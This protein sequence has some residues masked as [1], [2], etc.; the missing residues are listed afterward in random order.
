MALGYYSRFRFI[1]NLLPLLKRAPVLRRVVVVFAAGFEGKI[2]QDNFQGHG[3]SIFSYRNQVS[4]LITL[5]LEAVAQQASGVSFVHEFPGMVNTPG[6]NSVEGV[7]G[8]VSRVL[9]RLLGPF[10]C[11]P[12]VQSGERHL[13]LATS[14]MYTPAGNEDGE[15]D[16]AGV[17]FVSDG[18]RTTASGT[19]DLA[20]SGVYSVGS[21]GDTS[22]S[23]V[24]NVL[25]KFRNTGM[26]E[27]I[28][29]H[30]EG[31]FRRI[32]GEPTVAV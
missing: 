2:D 13:F 28:W 22:G 24:G 17:P 19:N 26:V 3:L 6:L 20:G 27:K 14:A 10:I 32:T 9:V 11:V 5:S 8:S 7:M 18:V 15:R 21:G 23:K 31:E 16:G 4:S 30:T 29:Q 12:I 1:V 25:D